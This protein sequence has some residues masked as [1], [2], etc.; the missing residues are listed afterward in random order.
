MT[1]GREWLRAAVGSVVLM[2]VIGVMGVVLVKIL[3]SLE[4]PEII[5]GL[6]TGI[7]AG[8]LAMHV[9]AYLDARRS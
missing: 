5:V 3:R 6:I 4:A 7:V 8:G 1:E 9:A 2:V